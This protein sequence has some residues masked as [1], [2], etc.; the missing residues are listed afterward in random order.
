MA[1]N[2]ADAI[3]PAV[4][5]ATLRDQFAMAALMGFVADSGNTANADILAIDSYKVADAML[6]ERKKERP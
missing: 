4:E 6:A 1:N 5:R 3:V 2:A